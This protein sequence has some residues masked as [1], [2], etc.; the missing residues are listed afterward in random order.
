MRWLALMGF[1]LAAMLPLF[2]DAAAI[3]PQHA[4][5]LTSVSH[6]GCLVSEAA[7]LCLVSPPRGLIVPLRLKIAPSRD[8]PACVSLESATRPGYFLRHQNSRLKVNQVGCD[9]WFTRDSAFYLIRNS[10]GTLSFRSY[11]YP[12]QYIS[13]TA[14]KNLYIS[15]DPEMP[16]RS[17]VL[18]N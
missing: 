13:V 11:D 2:A 15:T 12:E 6:P 17:F 5:T 8:F 4:Y 9:A 10:D 1:G 18:G 14:S 7:S 16:S 3:D